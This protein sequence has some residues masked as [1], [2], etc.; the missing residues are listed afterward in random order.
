METY[1]DGLVKLGKN[2][3]S[4]ANAYVNQYFLNIEF[5]KNCDNLTIQ[6]QL[7]I[8]RRHIWPCNYIIKNSSDPCF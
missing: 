2:I 3:F 1:Y 4:Q 5:V 6:Y 8:L 7:V